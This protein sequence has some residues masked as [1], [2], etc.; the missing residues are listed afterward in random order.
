MRWKIAGCKFSCNTCPKYTVFRWN[1][2]SLV[3]SKSG[4]HMH[5]CQRARFS[6]LRIYWRIR[7]CATVPRNATQ[8]VRTRLKTKCVTRQRKCIHA[9]ING[10]SQTCRIYNC[11]RWIYIL[12][13]LNIPISRTGILCCVQF[14]NNIKISL[15][16]KYL[17]Y[18]YPPNASQALHLVKIFTA[19]LFEAS[20]CT[21]ARLSRT[22]RLALYSYARVKHGVAKIAVLREFCVAI[23]CRARHKSQASSRGGSQ[24]SR[25]VAGILSR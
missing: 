15:P 20:F 16:E 22:S 2:G 24:R 13:E 10:A 12:L 5:A 14:R 7:M 19:T 3:P 18:F 25:G 11:E 1:F 6:Q 17:C 4:T 8:R 9:I 23:I 21:G